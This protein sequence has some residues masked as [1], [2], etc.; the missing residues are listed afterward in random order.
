MTQALIWMK[1]D[2][3]TDRLYVGKFLKHPDLA[4]QGMALF[5]VG[6]VQDFRKI[7]RAPFFSQ[8]NP[9]VDGIEARGAANIRQANRIDI[10]LGF[11]IPCSILVGFQVLD[12]VPAP[13][14]RTQ[15][16]SRRSFGRISWL[17][18]RPLT[19]RSERHA[20]AAADG[21]AGRCPRR[22]GALHCSEAN[23]LK[24]TPAFG[25]AR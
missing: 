16:L 11:W 18:A 1:D 21:C 9:Y 17:S 14:D 22:G 24:P 10:L 7:N 25:A 8:P 23:M 20:G 4:S 12:P 5:F 13:H 19:A 2:R 3:S 6:P 15:Q